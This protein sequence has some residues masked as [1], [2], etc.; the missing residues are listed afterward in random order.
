MVLCQPISNMTQKIL[1]IGMVKPTFTDVPATVAD[2]V[3]HTFEP[4]YIPQQAPL[5]TSQYNSTRDYIVPY[6]AGS[7]LLKRCI[8]G[9][10]TKN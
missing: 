5:R 9:N 7:K 4:T 2:S 3:G 1:R 8:P 6:N 10:Q